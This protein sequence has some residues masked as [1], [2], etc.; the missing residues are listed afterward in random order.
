MNNELTFGE[1]DTVSGGLKQSTKD[2]VTT[3]TFE[4]FGITFGISTGN[5]IT[6]TGSSS[7][8]STCTYDPKPA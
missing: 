8:P 2:G 7:S 5:G 3:T 6:C 1:L 4:I